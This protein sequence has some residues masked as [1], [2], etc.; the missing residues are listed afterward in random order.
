MITLA[1]AAK[2]TAS[3]AALALMVWGHKEGGKR[4]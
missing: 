2:L 4:S 1:L 3:A